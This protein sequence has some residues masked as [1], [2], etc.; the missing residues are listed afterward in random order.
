MAAQPTNASLYFGGDY[1]PEQ[2]DESV[3]TQDIALMQEAGVNL[4]TLGVFAWANIEVTDGVYRFEWLD[5]IIDLLH[6]GGIGVDLATATASPPAWLLKAHPEVRPLNQ[7]GVRAAHGGRQAY[8]ISS[9][10][11][12]TKATAL[13]AK[14]A[15][16]YGS[17]PAIK[18]WHA[19]N[20]YGCHNP[21]CF[22]DI[23]AA[24]WRVWLEE[25]YGTIEALNKAWGT[26]FW[27]QRYNSFDEVDTPKQTPMG[28]SPNPT[29]MLDFHRFGDWQIL[30]LYKSERDAIRAS[31]AK[32]P[33][34]T[35]F[36]SMKHFRFLNY[37][38]WAKEVDLVSTDHYLISEDPENQ[39]EMAFEAD[40]TRG[41]ARGENWLLM[42]HSTGAVNWQEVNFAKTDGQMRRNSLS[43]VARG[44]IGA[45]FFQWRASI[46]GSEKYHSALVPHA[47]TNTK[48]WRDV[49]SLGEELKTLSSVADKKVTPARV[50][51][52]FDHDSWWALSQRNLPSTE[53]SYPDL[54]HEWYAALWQIGARVDFIPAGLDRSELAKYDLVLLPMAY[55]MSDA[56]EGEYI[57]YATEGGSLIASY[58]SGISDRDDHVK[59]GGYGGRLVRDTLGVFVEEF[60]P[61]AASTTVGLQN[62]LQ[63]RQWCQLA[64]AVGA[65]AVTEFTDGPTP[66]SVALAK[67]WPGEKP[68]WY[69]GT[70][71]T[72]ESNQAFFSE[73]LHELGIPLKGGA[74]VECIQRGDVTFCI[75]HNDNK[76][77]VSLDGSRKE[78]H[79]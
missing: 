75:D 13:A 53:I 64:S 77:E 33:I 32:Q 24:A 61:V 30:E 8:C 40:L 11:Y 62:G 34:T 23:S 42:E 3:W 4:V 26:N 35:N 71:L 48:L 2:W 17:H 20:E 6:A 51:M 39:I 65:A 31:G 9:P 67:S 68:S 27:S 58:F 70:R 79:D 74:G 10:I 72:A 57:A 55:L 25:K 19:N 7:E 43:H 28:T 78:S 29:M 21:M 12:K 18:L 1:N 44:S 46:A 66:G 50:A 54:V 60:F 15:E 41:F 16:R 5:K 14:L 56:E 76:V 59:L 69:L 52:V 73:V 38:E 47:G 49:V 36:M 22:C 63:A 37:F 45:M